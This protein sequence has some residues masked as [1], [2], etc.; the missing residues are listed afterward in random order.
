MKCSS[1]FPHTHCLCHRGCHVVTC[2]VTA[3]ILWSSDRMADCVLG[4]GLRAHNIQRKDVVTSQASWPSPIHRN[5]PEARQ[6]FQARLQQKQVT[7]S[8]AP[9]LSSLSEVRVGVCPG[10]QPERGLRCFSHLY[11]SVVWRGHSEH[12]AFVPDTLFWLLGLQWQLGFLTFVYL[13]CS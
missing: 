10:I 7:D 5:R 11:G 8:L 13:F 4:T 6:S 1:W 3:T 9:S 12:P 2:M